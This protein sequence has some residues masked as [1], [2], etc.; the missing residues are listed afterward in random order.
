VPAWGI[1]KEKTVRFLKTPFAEVLQLVGFALTDQN[2]GEPA[3][4]LAATAA[5]AGRRGNLGVF[6]S[7]ITDYRSTG[8]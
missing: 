8:K 1:G 5:G 4:A 3:A 7:V 2:D 6:H